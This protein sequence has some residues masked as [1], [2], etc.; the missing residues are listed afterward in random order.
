MRIR[1]GSIL[2]R[3]PVST[4]ATKAITQLGVHTRGKM[5]RETREVREK[6]RGKEGRERAGEKVF[7]MGRATAHASSPLKGQEV[8]QFE[9]AKTPM[10]ELALATRNHPAASTVK[11][12]FQRSPEL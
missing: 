10:G 2:A 3:S 8:A 9:G 7:L 5:V 11:G 4:V 6:A 12:S 1:G